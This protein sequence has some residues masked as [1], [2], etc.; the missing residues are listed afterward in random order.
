MLALVQGPLL[1]S[2]KLPEITMSNY[3]F[4]P[5]DQHPVFLLTATI[6]LSAS[7]TVFLDSVLVTPS[8]NCPDISQSKCP[9]GSAVLKNDRIPSVLRLKSI[10]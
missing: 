6:T 3:D 8:S 4:L 10:S 9:L 7:V 5:F 2:D 1:L